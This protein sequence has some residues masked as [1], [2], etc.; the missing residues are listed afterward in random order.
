MFFFIV[1]APEVAPGEA[2]ILIIG[3]PLDW[4]TAVVPVYKKGSKSKA[5][6]WISV[7]LSTK[8][9]TINLY[10]NYLH[11]EFILL[12]HDGSNHFYNVAPNKYE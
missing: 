3:L 4:R 1:F 2:I 7:K 9:I 5:S 11:S 10:T 8:L 12:Q 6:N